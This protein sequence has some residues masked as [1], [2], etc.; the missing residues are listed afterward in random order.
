MHVSSATAGRL[1]AAQAP[2]RAGT[3]LRPAPC[4]RRPRAARVST[5]VVAYDW[6]K[7]AISW[8]EV[9][10]KAGLEVLDGFNVSKTYM[11]RSSPVPFLPPVRN[12]K[13]SKDVVIYRDSNSACPFCERV[14]LALEERG[15]PY[16]TVYIDL[17]ATPQ[18][19]LDDVAASGK[20]PALRV[21]GEYYTGSINLL[22]VLE[23]E[24]PGSKSLPSLLP[25]SSDFPRL[26]ELVD[27][28]DRDSIQS[29]YN[30]L[31]VRQAS[32]KDVLAKA[33]ELD[34][35]IG[36]RG[37]PYMVGDKLTVADCVYLPF[38]LRLRAR[39]SALHGVE[40]DDAK[41]MP[42][43]SKW[44]ETITDRRAVKMVMGDDESFIQRQCERDG[45]RRLPEPLPKAGSAEMLARQ[46]A[47]GK[48]MANFEFF[49]EDII[50]H[51]GL[52]RNRTSAYG[53]TVKSVNGHPP[54]PRGATLRAV[55]FHLRRVAQYLLTG[56]VGPTAGNV[57]ACAVG[58]ASL[59]YFRNAVRAPR[60][61]SAAAAVQCR[62]AVDRVC[63]DIFDGNYIDHHWGKGL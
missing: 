25:P 33:K 43:L 26:K 45:S 51:A 2:S 15:I 61:M 34:A 7:G 38:M 59:I 11:P 1:G 40:I 6:E 54:E 5:R 17:R 30:K 44:F 46:E 32:K 48:I 35:F 60:D 56:D 16:D 42:N 19:F 18:W 24:F 10:E 22:N 53:H 4:L 28:F 36:E 12:V 57:E 47:A 49:L 58:A 14:W 63:M 13:S 3:S 23:K 50:L 39:L 9:G 41:A 21:R 8:D 52:C 20:L 29:V 62:H 31:L 27:N 37:G 55:D